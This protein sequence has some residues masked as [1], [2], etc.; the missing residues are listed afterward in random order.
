MWIAYTIMVVVVVSGPF[1]RN[2][3]L[4]ESAAP[5]ELE[6]VLWVG[7]ETVDAWGGAEGR[8]S[9]LGPERAM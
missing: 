2:R 1:R 7:L 9:L 5:E 8:T 3:A 4:L 6:H